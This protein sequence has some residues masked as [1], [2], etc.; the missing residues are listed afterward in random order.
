MTNTPLDTS[1][2]E[3]TAE[4]MDAF[5]NFSPLDIPSP[6]Q[7]IGQPRIATEPTL[8]SFSPQQQQ[9]I[10]ARAGGSSP[11]EISAAIQPYLL[12]KRRELLIKGGA[13]EGATETQRTML[14][15]ANRVRLLNEGI[16]R[17][18]AELGAVLRHDTVTGEDGTVR[19]VPVYQHQGDARTAREAERDRLA[20]EMVLIAGLQGV[21]E[22]TE[23]NRRDAIR[24]RDMTAQVEEQREI[25]RRAD[26]LAR[27]ERINRAAEQRAKFRRDNLV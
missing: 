11:E 6:V 10:L 27:E 2:D 23:A 19:A 9:E 1:S 7:V 3:P 16:Q 22:L 15:Q 4:E 24:A 8:A 14:E 13:G 20:H 17:I 12:E 26:Q 5:N 25:T 18:D 21:R